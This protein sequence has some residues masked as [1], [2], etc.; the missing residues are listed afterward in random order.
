MLGLIYGNVRL[1][2]SW[3]SKNI[4]NPDTY[5]YM[6]KQNAEV[7]LCTES[8]KKT[9]DY[10]INFQI[11]KYHVWIIHRHYYH[12]H[13]SLCTVIPVEFYVTVYNNQYQ[14]LGCVQ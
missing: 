2:I 1:T 12:T 11:T 3:C 5:Y 4:E 8:E 14:N 9:L 7:T 13:I 10:W 6:I